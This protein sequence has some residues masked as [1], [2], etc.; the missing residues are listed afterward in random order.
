M[1]IKIY[2]APMLNGNVLITDVIS[3]LETC[4]NTL[5]SVNDMTLIDVMTIDIPKRNLPSAHPN[6]IVFS[7]AP[8][9]YG[10]RYYITSVIA[11]SLATVQ[12]TIARDYVH[13][14]FSATH[15]I[16]GQY[17]EGH[18]PLLLNRGY[19]PPVPDGNIKWIKRNC[20]ILPT[21]LGDY[22]S[23][24]KFG[25]VMRV[26]LDKNDIASDSKVVL[27]CSP[28][29]TYVD[30]IA[31]GEIYNV[32][33]TAKKLREKLTFAGDISYTEYDIEEV[34]NVWLVPEGFLPV[35]REN[36]EVSI[37]SNSFD[38]SDFSKYRLGVVPTSTFNIEAWVPTFSNVKTT[39]GN[40]LINIELPHSNA[41]YPVNVVGLYSTDSMLSITLRVNGQ[42]IDM[43]PSF[44]LGSNMF[45][46]SSA[47]M[48]GK[49]SR[50][51]GVLSGIMGLTVGI[52][53][54]NPVAIAGGAISTI[55]SAT[56]GIGGRSAVAASGTDGLQAVYA[57][58]IVNADPAGDNKLA[59]NLVGGLAVTYWAL[60]NG[61]NIVDT[62]RSF[63]VS[64]NMTI[65]DTL[66]AL[67]ASG[68]SVYAKF[69]NVRVYC[70]NATPQYREQLVEM[71]TR[72]V[73][74][75]NNAYVPIF[76]TAWGGDVHDL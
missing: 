65:N 72:G 51:L 40:N 56:G 27:V 69:D 21:G 57:D 11:I 19:S 59:S 6:Y 70:L 54:Q 15:R 7:E 16:C 37:I 30:S 23:R 5:L 20:P 45:S 2:D 32:L 14:E 35:I 67:V 8:R 29:Y 43:T 24:G 48:S 13:E 34:T 61:E 50:G 68:Q 41:T 75:A 44:D 52:S 73:H 3:Y 9:S 18:L 49:I 76:S 46:N 4:S 60:D 55:S 58:S 26:V 63:G 74:I 10:A 12:F 25:F 42:C 39:V 1:V 33:S 66:S 47:T 31:I 53:T 17:V 28:T 38:G 64:T 71:L 22:G 62:M 36:Y